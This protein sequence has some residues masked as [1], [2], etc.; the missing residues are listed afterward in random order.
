MKN[1]SQQHLKVAATEP[2]HVVRKAELDQKIAVG[3]EI[4][5]HSDGRSNVQLLDSDGQATGKIVHNVVML[6]RQNTT[7]V[8]VASGDHHETWDSKSADEILELAA[9]HNPVTEVEIV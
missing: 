8:P 2:E 9:K 1:F 6:P 4:E 5:R 3:V 7:P